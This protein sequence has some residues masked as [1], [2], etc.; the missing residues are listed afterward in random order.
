MNIEFLNR[1]LNEKYSDLYESQKKALEWT[2]KM[3]KVEDYKQTLDFMINL[4]S[5]GFNACLNT[6][7]EI[8]DE[9]NK[10]E[11]EA[12]SR[13][14]VTPHTDIKRHIKVKRKWIDWSDEDANGE[15]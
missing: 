1:R 15:R 8:V 3:S 9:A 5:E 7:E 6:M 12:F 2:F 4:W 11:R 14:P 10:I 13:E